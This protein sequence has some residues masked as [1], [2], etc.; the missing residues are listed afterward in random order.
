MKKMDFRK[1][2]ATDTIHQKP[3]TST[4]NNTRISTSIPE[5]KD[6]K[7]DFSL[8]VLKNLNESSN[9]TTSAPSPSKKNFPYKGYLN[10]LNKVL[11]WKVILYS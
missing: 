6:I 2:D 8:S 4:A 7:L 9:K 10:K 11:F 5:A 3:T 1:I